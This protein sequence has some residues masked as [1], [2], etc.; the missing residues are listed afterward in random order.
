MD[1]KVNVN[2]FLIMCNISYYISHDSLHG[3]RHVP[4]LNILMWYTAKSLKG[5][6]GPH[7]GPTKIKTKYYWNNSS[8]LVY[9]EF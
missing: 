6:Y 1:R 4:W 7:Y 9:V 2:L 8:I 3:V 5:I